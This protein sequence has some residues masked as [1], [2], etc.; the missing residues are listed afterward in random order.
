MSANAANPNPRSGDDNGDDSGSGDGGRSVFGFQRRG[1]AE[2][3]DVVRAAA[4]AGAEIHRIASVANRDDLFS[5]FA[6]SYSFPDWARP[7]FD[8]L[9]DLLCDLSWRTPASQV[10]IIGPL[11]QL[12]ANDPQAAEILGEVLA[13]LPQNWSSSTT[14]FGVIELITEKLDNPERV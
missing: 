4:A 3:P 5:R 11:D 14:P 2:Y 1:L 6:A 12:R 9:W 8:A 13:E 7:N 10:L